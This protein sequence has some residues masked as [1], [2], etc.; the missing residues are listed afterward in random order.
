MLTRCLEIDS[1]Q[2]V[3]KDSATLDRYASIGVHAN[4]KDMVR[5]SDGNDPDYRNVLSELQRLTG[6]DNQRPEAELPL[7]FPTSSMLFAPPAPT[8]PSEL[9]EVKRQSHHSSWNQIPSLEGRDETATRVARTPNQATKP[10][11]HF[12]GTFHTNGGKLYQGNE[13]NSGGGPMTF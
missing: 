5:F 2:I 11:N 7:S 9:P 6:S 3:P 13:F 1:C 4:H 12:S 8:A 10:V